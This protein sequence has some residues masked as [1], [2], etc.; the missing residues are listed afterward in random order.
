MAGKY[1]ELISTKVTPEMYAELQDL[2]EK[3]DRNL[4]NMVRVLITEA[5]YHRKAGTTKY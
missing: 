3:E 1:T 2:A 4:S 5:L